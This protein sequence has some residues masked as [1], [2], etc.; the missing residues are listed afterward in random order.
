MLDVPGK[1]TEISRENFEKAISMLTVAITGWIEDQVAEDRDNPI[2]KSKATQKANL[3]LQATD[4][5]RQYGIT[6][7]RAASTTVLTIA[8]MWAQSQVQEG[9]TT[10]NDQK[11]QR[12][13]SYCNLH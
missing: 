10:K 3:L 7:A 4:H 5:L 12:K 8:S 11:E 9:I 6:G 13:Q 2:K 1:D